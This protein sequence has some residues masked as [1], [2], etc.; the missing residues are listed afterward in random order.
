MRIES[1]YKSIVNGVST[2]AAVNRPPGFAETQVNFRS[3]TVKKLVRRPSMCWSNSLP[4]FSGDVDDLVTHT[5]IRDSKKFDMVLNKSTGTMHAYIDGE[6]IKSVELGTDYMGDD[7]RLTTIGYETFVINPS[8]AVERGTSVDTKNEESE[9]YVLYYNV[10]TAP[11]YED[12]FIIE[13][14]VDSG[15]PFGPEYVGVSFT[16]KIV[17]SDG[18]SG[19]YSRDTTELASE[20][21]EEI[22][23]NSNF[24]A[25]SEGSSVRVEK[26]DGT[27][28]EVDPTLTIKT[29]DD[30]IIQFL[31]SVDDLEYLPKYALDGDVVTAEISG[32][33]TYYLSANAK[34]EEDEGSS[35]LVECIWEET[36]SPYEVYDLNVDTLPIRVV[37]EDSTFSVVKEWKER[38]AGDDDTNPVPDFVGK[39]ITDVGYFQNRLV[40]LAEDYLLMSETNDITNFWLQSVLAD[41]DN[42]TISV[43]STDVDTDDFEAITTH[44][45]DILVFAANRQFKISGSTAATPSTVT[46]EKTTSYDYDNSVNPVVLGNT[47]VFP[48]K[49][50]AYTSLRRYFIDVS[51]DNDF[52]MS[53]TEAVPTLIRNNIE[54]LVASSN[55]EVLVA[56]SKEYGNV[57]YVYEQYSEGDTKI[58]QSSWSTWELPQGVAVKNMYARDG[59]IY[60]LYTTEDDTLHS[61]TITLEEYYGSSRDYVRLDN[62]LVVETSGTTAEIPEDYS[63]EDFTV[64]CGAGTNYENRVVDYTLDGTTLTLARNVGEGELY[65]GVLFTSRY[66]PTRPYLYTEEGVPDT[67][68][69]L[70]IAKFSLEVVNTNELHMETLSDYYET[71]KQTFNGRLVSGKFNLLGE[72]PVYS[73]KVVFPF[74][75]VAD[76]AKPSFYVDNHLN[77]TIS[78]I[79]WTGKYNRASRRV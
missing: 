53:L 5:Y 42:D 77:C 49:S 59:I 40:L 13:I 6:F 51:T 62:L 74:G 21:A 28:F 75:Q 65:I 7:L 60:L 39:R 23:D 26:T 22:N 32:D 35:S 11:D 69:R 66:T 14:K 18:T 38:Q 57:L 15:D 71:T 50:G 24:T 30:F 55:E 76:Y 78:K 27:A 3:D 70:Q 1:G 72:E 67:N 19:T 47:V 54:L 61:G 44:D 8:V 63:Q 43:T 17:S 36:R 34:Y 2:V 12:E 48:A 29:G 58:A 52:S 4:E 37:Y 31:G 33:D 79:E 9:N 45:K 25:I 64:V 56:K 10:T 16:F 20:I 46:I 41:Y 73:G 68:D